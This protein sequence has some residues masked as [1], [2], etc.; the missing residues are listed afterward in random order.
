MIFGKW[1][2]LEVYGV[3]EKNYGLKQIIVKLREGEYKFIY[4]LWPADAQANLEPSK[5]ESSR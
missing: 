2:G 4:N 1:N 3:F 5:I